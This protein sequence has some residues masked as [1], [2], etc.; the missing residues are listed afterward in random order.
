MYNYHS[1]SSRR[2]HYN[3][4]K[5]GCPWNYNS[6]NCYKL[7]Y[8]NNDF[9]I[10]LLYNIWCRYAPA[11]EEPRCAHATGSRGRHRKPSIYD[12]T[13]N[14]CG[15]GRGRCACAKNLISL[16][17]LPRLS[18]CSSPRN[19][20]TA[21]DTQHYNIMLQKYYYFLLGDRHIRVHCGRHM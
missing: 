15:G 11:Q 13:G 17:G 2:R 12:R 18:A 14:D 7:L 8:C 3:V 10:S 16:D 20:R 4:D 21:A 19:T 5:R 6:C 9:I 1:R